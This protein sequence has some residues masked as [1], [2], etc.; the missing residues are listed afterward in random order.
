[1]ETQPTLWFTDLFGVEQPQYQLPF[2]DFNVYSDV[3]LYID[4]YAITKDPSDLAAHCHNAIVSFFETLLDAVKADDRLALRSLLNS[5]LTEP[6]QICLGVSKTARGGRGIGREQEGQIV[7]AL[8]G[9]SAAKSGVLEALQ[10]LELHIPHVG[11]DKISDLVANIILHHLA[12]FTEETCQAYGIA[13]RPCPVDGFWD[14][15]QRKW[16]GGFFNLPVHGTSSYVLVPK[17]FVRRERDLM[18]HSRFYDKYILDTLQREL[19]TADDSLVRTLG[20]GMR[21]VTKEDIKHDPRFRPSKEFIS[22]FIVGHPEVIAAYRKELEESYR[23][24]DPA[25]WS[26]RAAVDDPGV[27]SILNE[28]ASLAPGRKDANRYHAAV[29]QLVRFVFDYAL[30]NFE[31]EYEMDQGRGRI[32]IIADNYAGGGFF[33]EARSEYGASTVPIECKNYSDDLGNNEFNQIMDRMGPTTSRLGLI[34]CRTIDDRAALIDHLNDRWL[35]QQ[36]MVLV[37]DDSAL[38][39]LSELRLARSFHGIESRLRLL[40]RQVRY[41]NS[42]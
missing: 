35:R 21:R 40:V 18:N 5:R 10:E 41:G 31:C 26:G 1:M 30:E 16:D 11:P 8:R 9:S 17:R 3:P 22:E 15:E 42:A 36:K 39:Q 20:S 6:Q 13:T 28:I 25:V 12:G 2:I 4:P 7:E 23:P 32:D 38:R 37:I 14:S 27:Q 19:L 29:F 34:F 33:M 24:E